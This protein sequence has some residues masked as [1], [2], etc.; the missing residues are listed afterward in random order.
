MPYLRRQAV[1]A[2]S[3]LWRRVVKRSKAS[4]V[5]YVG[6]SVPACFCLW[7]RVVKRSKARRVTY[8][9][10]SVPA[11]SCLW[12]R[13]EERSKGGTPYL[14]RQVRPGLLLCRVAEEE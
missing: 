12:R 8:V 9:G 10:K 6:K 4:R 11:C 14:R 13:V 5:T 2:C 7:R 3:C 1:P